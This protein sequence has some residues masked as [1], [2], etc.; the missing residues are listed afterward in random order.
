[1]IYAALFNTRR[2]EARILRTLQITT[3]N[4]T[5]NNNIIR[6]IYLKMLT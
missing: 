5:E 1:M 3:N 2:E 6:D 4:A